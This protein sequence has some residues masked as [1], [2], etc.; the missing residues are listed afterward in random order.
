MGGRVRVWVC[1]GTDPAP[2]GPPPQN[3]YE[4]IRSEPFKIPED[5]GNDL[6]HTFFNPDR[7]G[8]LLKLGAPAPLPPRPPGPRPPRD[9]PTVATPTHTPPLAPAPPIPA[10]SSWVGHAH[11]GHAHP[12]ARPSPGLHP[13]T[14]YLSSQTEDWLIQLG[15][16]R[17]HRPR[18]P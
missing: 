8:W 13:P 15:R 2:P 17:P 7:E 4:S 16:T 9:T 10:C 5:D 14:R 18:P 6:T 12:G 3:L 11:P 1:P